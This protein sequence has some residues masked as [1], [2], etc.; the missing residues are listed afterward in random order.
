MPRILLAEDDPSVRQSLAEY[1][2]DWCDHTVVAVPDGEAAC[3]ELLD[4]TQPFDAAILDVRLPLR[5][6][7]EILETLR[8]DHVQLPVILFTGSGTAALRDHRIELDPNV[9]IL[10]KPIDDLRL[11]A[12][13]LGGMLSRPGEAS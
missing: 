8:R 5:S 1:L 9:R 3:T 11:I 10:F 2:A 6:G 12:E 4:D 7:L 13:T